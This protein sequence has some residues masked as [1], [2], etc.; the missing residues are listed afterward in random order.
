MLQ[1]DTLEDFDTWHAQVN[2]ALGYPKN[3]TAGY[4]APISGTDG[5]FYAPYNAE[6]PIEF[7]TVPVVQD[8]PIV[9][10]EGV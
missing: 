6:L 2:V 1:F 9:V 3:G 4:T 7:V 8:P 10:D 5:K